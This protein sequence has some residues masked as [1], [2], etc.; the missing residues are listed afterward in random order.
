MSRVILI[1]NTVRFLKGSQLFWQILNRIRP[2]RYVRNV[3]VNLE[4]KPINFLRTPTVVDKFKQPLGFTFLNQSIE[5]DTSINWNYNKFGKLWTYNLEYFDY[6]AQD[7]ISIDIG[8]RLINDFYRFSI[9]YKRILEPYPVSLRAINIIRFSVKNHLFNEEY[10]SFVY[11]ELDYLDSH[12]EYHLL[13]NHL[14]ENSFSLLLGGAFFQNNS[15]VSS[16]INILKSEL[17]EQVIEDGGHFELSPMYHCIIFYRLLELIDWYKT[18]DSKDINFLNFCLSKAALMRSWLEQICFENGDIPLFNDSANNIAFDTKFLFQYA[19]EL[20]IKSSNMALNTSGYRSYK[21]SDYEIKMDFA[22]I[23]A[24]YQPGHAHADALSFILYYKGEPLFVEQGTSTY[25][26]GNRREL[27]RSTDAH[28]TVVVNNKNQSEVWGGFRVGKRAKSIILTEKDGFYEGEHNGYLDCGVKHRRQY[29][30][31]GACVR[32]KDILDG[33]TVGGKAAFHVHPEN[34][35]EIKGNTV[36]IS[37]KALC[38][39]ENATT[40]QIE[41]YDYAESYNRYQKAK[42]IIVKFETILDTTIT[43]N[44]L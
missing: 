27:E 1:F 25:E 26:A 35:L 38:E 8:R 21:A 19:D 44:N 23:G 43:F 30:F 12:C 39:F 9:E 29:R 34:D 22:E 37:N 28:N 3:I 16:G 17:Q 2:K 33:E 10:M 18:Y 20:F 7:N 36:R 31:D 4:C 24:K 15:W 11:Q 6:L 42:R 41:T 5:F 32:I 14:L 40:I 13:G